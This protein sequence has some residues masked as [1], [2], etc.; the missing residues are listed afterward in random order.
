MYDVVLDPTGIFPLPNG[1]YSLAAAPAPYGAHFVPSG[2]IFDPAGRILNPWGFDF[3][4]HLLEDNSDVHAVGTTPHIH[5][6]TL[7]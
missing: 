6:G 5:T 1:S 2:L 3:A 7:C 4:L